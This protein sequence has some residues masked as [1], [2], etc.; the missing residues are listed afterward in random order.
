MSVVNCSN[1]CLVIWW[2]FIGVRKCGKLL[3]IYSILVLLFVIMLKLQDSFSVQLDSQILVPTSES[4]CLNSTNTFVDGMILPRV[5]LA[6]ILKDSKRY[7]LKLLFENRTGALYHQA[8]KVLDGLNWNIYHFG[9]VISRSSKY[10]IAVLKRFF[11]GKN[12]FGRF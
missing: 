5:Y 12:L 9:L 2:M 4:S 6:Y 1:I 10:S 3:V 11:G 7:L 8:H